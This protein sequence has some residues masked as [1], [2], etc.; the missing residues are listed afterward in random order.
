MQKYRNK[1]INRLRWRDWPWT[2]DFDEDKAE[3]KIEEAKEEG[4]NRPL[5]K[6]LTH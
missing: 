1:F 4:K 6:R 3:K 2:I 5:W